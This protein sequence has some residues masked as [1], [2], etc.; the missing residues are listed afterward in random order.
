[1]SGTESG[2]VPET[3]DAALLATEHAR[4]AFDDAAYLLGALEPAELAAYSEHLLVCPVCQASV[5]E[6]TGLPPLLASLPAAELA[7]LADSSA[8]NDPERAQPP[9]TLLPRLLEE[10]ARSRRRR[11]W[12]IAASGFVAACLLAVLVAVGAHQWSD[13]GRPQQLAMASV[14]PNTGQLHATVTLTG[15]DRSTR[16]ELDCG[17]R[18]APGGYP[19]SSA[20]SYRMVVIN[21]QGQARDLGSWTP[22]PGEDV[23][24]IRDSPWTRQNLG[25]IE[26]S[27]AHGVTVL[28]LAL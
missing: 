11:G 6:L 1:M 25:K 4:F 8:A 3:P 12:R 23:E 17:Y 26:V 9:A 28:R 22:Q 14:G 2:G 24:I 15:S 7:E 13:A 18:A 27:D 16:I 5:A 20:P 21:R 19:A 10:V